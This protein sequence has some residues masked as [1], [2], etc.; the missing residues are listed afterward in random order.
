LVWKYSKSQ[1]QTNRRRLH[2]YDIH[3]WMFQLAN[4]ASNFSSWAGRRL[5][6]LFS[7]NARKA[8]ANTAK[9]SQSTSPIRTSLPPNEDRCHIFLNSQRSPKTGQHPK[10]AAKP[11]K[12]RLSLQP[13]QR[14]AVRCDPERGGKD[15]RQEHKSSGPEE[16][17]RAPSVRKA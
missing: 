5:E 17:N 2:P 11:S 13:V 3:I 16:F 1:S 7:E 10:A 8:T 14:S 15:R 12:S 9:Q 4:A 6:T